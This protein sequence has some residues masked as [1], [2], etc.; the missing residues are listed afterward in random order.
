[1]HVALLQPFITT[2]VPVQNERPH[3]EYERMLLFVLD[4]AYGGHSDVNSVGAGLGGAVGIAEGTT[5]GSTVGEFDGMA[6]GGTVGPA[7]GVG[8]GSDV[9]RSEGVLDGLGV[10]DEDGS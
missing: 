1:M 4:A 6:V 7:D 10:G 3:T 5:E 2:V 9:G 8:D